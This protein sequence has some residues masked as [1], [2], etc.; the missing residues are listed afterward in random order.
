VVERRK[1][2]RVLRNPSLKPVQCFIHVD[3]LIVLK[4]GLY[5]CVFAPRCISGRLRSDQKHSVRGKAC[6]RKDALTIGRQL[7]RESLVTPTATF[8]EIF[9]GLLLRSMA[10]KC[11]QNLKFVALSVPGITAGI[12]KLW[13]APEYAEYAVQGHPRSLILVPIKCAYM[14][15]Y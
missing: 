4:H 9:N 13:T 6:Y 11:V 7:L 1:L 2:G 12:L 5:A 15:S 14:T 10:R 8:P 3:V